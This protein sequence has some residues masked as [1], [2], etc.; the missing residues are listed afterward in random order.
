MRALQGTPRRVDVAGERAPG[1]HVKKRR[2]DAEQQVAELLRTAKESL[3]LSVAF[4]SRLD[5]AT[6]HLKVVES[7]VPFLFQEGATQQQS[8]SL[9]QAILDKKLPPVIPDLRK[10][11]EAMRLPAARMPRIRSYVSVPVVLSDGTLYG[12]FCAAGLTSD[13]EL[14]ERDRALMDVLASAAAVVIEPEVRE[15]ERRTEI[16]RRLGPVVADGGP[17]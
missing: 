3:Q 10:H 11:P 15:Q 2:S 4:L 14:T 17:V 13:K 5:G 8:T 12:T 16:E 7:S 6:Q 9:C 1:G